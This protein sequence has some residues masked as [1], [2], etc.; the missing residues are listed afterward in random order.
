MEGAVKPWEWGA[1]PAFWLTATLMAM[2][3]E[4]E[5]REYHQKKAERKAARSRG[6]R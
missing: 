6:K 1:V 2:E 3:A 4:H 5:A